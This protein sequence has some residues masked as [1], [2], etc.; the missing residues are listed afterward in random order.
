MGKLQLDIDGPLEMFQSLPH[1]IF[2]F[3]YQHYNFMEPY[4]Q[5][6]DHY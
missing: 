1:L 6:I 2:R 5:E 4:L 3:R